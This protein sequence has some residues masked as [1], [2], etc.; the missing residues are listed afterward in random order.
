MY[1]SEFKLKGVSLHILKKNNGGIISW[2]NSDCY[3]VLRYNWQRFYIKFIE[4]KTALTENLD[5]SD[6][7]W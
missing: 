4:C 7:K 6:S 5:I 1:E 3:I 2:H